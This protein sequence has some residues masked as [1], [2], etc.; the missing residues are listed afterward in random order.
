MDRGWLKSG[1]TKNCILAT[2]IEY[3]AAKIQGPLA[4]SRSEVLITED[5][6]QDSRHWGNT[7]LYER[8]DKAYE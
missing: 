5:A 3:A 1:V 4:P 2:D 6:V 8:V 7:S